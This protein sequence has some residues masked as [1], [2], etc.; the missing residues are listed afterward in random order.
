MFAD[1]CAL[2]FNTRADLILGTKCLYHHLLKFGLAYA[3]LANQ[4]ASKTEAMCFPAPRQPHDSG[5]QTRFRVV[6]GFA[7]FTAEFKYLGSLIRYTLEITSDADIS[8]KLGKATTAFAALR[9][10]L[11]LLQ[12]TR[13][14]QGKGHG[15]RCAV[16]D[17]LRWTGHQ[18][19]RKLWLPR[20]PGIWFRGGGISARDR[21]DMGLHSQQ[22]T[23]PSPDREGEI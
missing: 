11:I 1:D 17:L 9:A 19:S 16:F 10:N 20:R 5:D 14:S 22:G 2:L 21:D 12:Q 7:T 15:L 18:C 3:H 6:D 8:Y 4:V 23:L 13:Q